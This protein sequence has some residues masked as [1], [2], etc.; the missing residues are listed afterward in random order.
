[1][2][3]IKPLTGKVLV[4]VSAPRQ[5]TAGG[6]EIPNRSKS[7]EEVQETHLDPVKPGALTGIVRACG[8]WPTIANGMM[9][10]PEFG[11]G[12]KVLISPQAG[13]PMQRSIG[14]R[15]RMVKQSD[16]LAVIRD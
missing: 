16:I 5:T 10:M 15:Y 8:A 2:T 9:L 14:E 11:I 6:L 1:M 13:I 7:P 12:D 4:E 3:N